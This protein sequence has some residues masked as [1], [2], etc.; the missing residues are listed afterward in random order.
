MKE[1]LI[2]DQYDGYELRYPFLVE[3]VKTQLEKQFWT[4]TEARVDLDEVEM[5]YAL[6]DEHLNF[7]CVS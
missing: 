3:H 4:A 7:Y 2:T 5:L 1:R 6:T